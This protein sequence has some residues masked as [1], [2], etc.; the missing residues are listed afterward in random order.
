[1]KSVIDVISPLIKHQFPEVYRDTGPE[2]IL[3]VEAYF[4]W[5][6]SNFQK[7]ELESTTG[8]N[9]ND[10]V[11]QGSTTG[12]VYYVDSKILL[13]RINGFTQFNCNVLCNDYTPITS[14]SGGQ[15]YIKYQWRVNPIYNARKL[16]NLRDIDTTLDS[17]VVH[18]KEKYLKNIDFDVATN[19]KLL[20]KNSLDLY[21]AK[22]TS[23]AVDL[24]FRLMYGAES[25]VLYPGEKM[26]RLSDGEWHRPVY[27]EITHSEYT[28][29]L[30]GKEITGAISGA[31]AFVEKYIKRIVPGGF[32]YI[33]Q[34]SAVRG[35]FVRDEILKVG[36]VVV[37]A[38][39]VLGSLNNTTITAGGQGFSVGDIVKFNSSKGEGALARVVSIGEASG[40]IEFDIIESGYGYT[41]NGITGLSAAETAQRSQTIVSEN[42]IEV[43]GVTTSNTQYFKLFEG[44]TQPRAQ[45]V[46]DHATNNALLTVGSSV[47]VSNAT[48]NTAFGV[49]MTNDANTSNT[50]IGTLLI[51]I[52]DNG[53]VTAGDGVYLISNASISAN[54]GSVNTAVSATGNVMGWSI[55]ATLSLGSVS[56]SAG[57][58]FGDVVYQSDGIIETANAVIQSINITGISGN[59]EVANL[60]GAFV[61]SLPVLVKS[62]PTI[63]GSVT[64]VKTSV[65]IYNVTNAFSTSYNL[66][67]FFSLT[68]TSANVNVI[69]EGT[70]AAYKI[71]SLD[72]GETVYLNTDL[73]G[74]NNASNVPF[75]N[76]SLNATAYG[77]SKTPAANASSVLFDALSFSNFTIGSIATLNNINPGLDYNLDPFTL[78][79]QPLITG[80]DKKD[81]VFTVANSTGSFSIGETIEQDAYDLLGYTLQA[82]G[83]GL[84]VGEKVYQNTW[85]GY[86]Y[87]INAA[88]NTINVIN[89]TAA[90]T[91]SSISGNLYSYS[92]ASYDM[93]ILS[94]TQANVSVTA[95][96]IIKDVIDNTVY[97]K[98]I[99]FDDYFLVGNTITG[100]VTGATSIITDIGTDNT[101]R[102]IGYNADI[103][104]LAAAGSGVVKELE[105]TDSGLG[106]MNDQ[107]L[108]FVSEGGER[109]GTAVAIING[110]GKSKGYYRRGGS[111]ASADYKI[112]DGYYYQEYSYEIFSSVPLDKYSEMF[113]KVVH[114]AGTKLFG[115]VLV[116]SFKPVT[117]ECI[118]S[119]VSVSS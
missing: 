98:R 16:P 14:S 38:P 4:Q 45:I 56:N 104:A 84:S 94:A 72:N 97:V 106:Y 35:E 66:P 19:K 64:A 69:G 15:S 78:A 37:G 75:L 87:S 20:V 54:I 50:S 92:N 90:F 103:S 88:A 73:V 115:S 118:E 55:K 80:L 26:F 3:F 86:V 117:I 110:I 36:Q 99:Q 22:G 102:V 107:E 6:E 7:L 31:K 39:V 62:K 41:V 89:A 44:V 101:S 113:K 1:M 10:T 18:F 17:F 100:D 71:G 2:F 21:R 119:S 53:T 60:N 29:N 43:T 83:S 46:Y 12:V 96:G 13:V 32:V 40:I 47:R 57:L 8:F 81:Y 85:S 24:F 48:H 33:L 28:V 82:N 76:V 67:V 51:G 27:L 77:F 79:Y 112:Q 5:L 93:D 49:I 63:N 11:T 23:R 65:G 105:I 114:V 59:V 61:N 25:K 108:V 116:E 9:V 74:A 42:N 111:F 52:T 91:N 58:A 95:K 34:L 70:D 30:V 109:T 68:G